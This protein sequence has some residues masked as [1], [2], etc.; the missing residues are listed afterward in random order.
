MYQINSAIASPTAQAV[1]RHQRAIAFVVQ[2][3]ND[4]FWKERADL[5]NP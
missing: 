3:R 4:S 5:F 2:C 1:P